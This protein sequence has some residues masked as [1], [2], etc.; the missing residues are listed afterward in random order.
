[1]GAA[2][3]SPLLE[4]GLPLI[5]RCHP[6]HQRLSTAGETGILLSFT[7]LHETGPARPHSSPDRSRSQYIANC[8]FRAK[9][10]VAHVS[11][12]LMSQTTRASGEAL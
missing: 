5:E 3:G 6:P 8:S 1:M 9:P 4:L 7:T 12:S 10:D 2:E 11:V